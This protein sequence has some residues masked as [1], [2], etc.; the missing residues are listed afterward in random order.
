MK[1]L[2][3]VLSILIL[4]L[5]VLVSCDDTE[6]EI[7]I[8][9]DGY[10]VV[11]GVTTE[12]VADKDDVITVDND[13]YVIVNGIK[14]EHQVAPDD[15]TKIHYS[16]SDYGIKIESL[17]PDQ[18]QRIDEY[19]FDCQNIFT[20]SYAHSLDTWDYS[21]FGAPYI[22][23]T[24]TFVYD[25]STV[26]END[27]DNGAYQIW[28]GIKALSKEE[29]APIMYIE[30]SGFLNYLGDTYKPTSFAESSLVYG[31]F[32]FEDETCVP[33]TYK[34]MCSKYYYYKM[35]ERT[36]LINCG[37]KYSGEKST[38]ALVD[39]YQAIQDGLLPSDVLKRLTLSK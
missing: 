11:S 14:T 9:A 6:A 12:I 30:L 39:L 28:N 36:D 21:R 38:E 10:V 19:V 5:C 16:P 3:R 13:G 33:M 20:A 29:S 7:S 27:L 35:P 23:F 1:K 37:D 34:S 2:L 15:S 31:Y 4:T 22:S 8:N 17:T 24:D 18:Q 26:N 32:I 25:F